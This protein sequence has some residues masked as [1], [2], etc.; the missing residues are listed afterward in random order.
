MLPPALIP[1]AEF[2]AGALV[3]TLVAK[4]LPER[5]NV[6]ITFKE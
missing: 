4:G 5:I 6:E 3:A 2:V 1:A